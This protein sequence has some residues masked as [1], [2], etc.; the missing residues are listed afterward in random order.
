MIIACP[1]CATRYVVPDSAI[2]VEGRTVR[3]AKCKHSWF[4][5]GPEIAVPDRATQDRTREDAPAPSKSREDAR[6]YVGDAPPA[7]A[8]TRDATAPPAPAQASA[9]KAPVESDESEP[10]FSSGSNGQDEERL[11]SDAGSPDPSFG[12]SFDEGDPPYGELPDAPPR[13]TVYDDTVSQFDYSPPF[14]PRRNYVKLWTWAAGIFAILALGTVIA[15]ST[16]GLPSWMPVDRPLF[17]VAEPDLE[18][19][20]PVEEQERRTLPNGTEYFGARI[21][22]TNTARETRNVPPILIVLR[23]G[24]ERIVF[25]W[26]VTPPQG[27]L[28]PGESITI[29]E[30]MTDVPRS[31]VFADIGWAPR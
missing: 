4:Q 24:R 28:A 18:L 1:A 31:A 8:A 16:I 3:C 11:F 17:A 9:P 12:P 20:F 5:E 21:I 29:N 26:E 6:P 10:G 19:E 25:S 27:S 22:V 2:G 30:A 15:A 14:R 13:P 7:A 23:D